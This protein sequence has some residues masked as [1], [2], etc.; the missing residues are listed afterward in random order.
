MWTASSPLGR[1]NITVHS[2]FGESGRR[3]WLKWTP[4]SL[5]HGSLVQRHGGLLPSGYW[6]SMTTH[7]LPLPA[8]EHDGQSGKRGLLPPGKGGAVNVYIMDG[9]HSILAV[10]AGGV[11]KLQGTG[12]SKIQRYSILNS[13]T[14]ISARFDQVICKKG[15][16]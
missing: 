7:P 8:E 9:A 14:N 16:R 4:S 10:G 5:R 13:H 12:G 6:P 2:L 3:T 15:T 1:E 11:T